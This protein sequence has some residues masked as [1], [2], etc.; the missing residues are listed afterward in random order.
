MKKIFITCAVALSALLSS[1]DMGIMPV[2]P[3]NEEEAVETV[4]DCRRFRAGFYTAFR[5]QSGSVTQLVIPEI[6]ADCF[7]ALAPL[8]GNNA[9]EM[10]KANFLP[11]TDVFGSAWASLYSGIAGVNFYLPRVEKLLADGN[12]SEANRKEIELGRGEAHFFR[13]F[14]YYRLFDLFC[15][16][17]SDELKD[18]PAL[19]LPLVTEYY[20]TTDRSTYKGRSTMAETFKLIYDDLAI[21]EKAVT[22][23]ETV[24]TENLKPGAAYLNSMVIKALRARLALIQGNKADAVKY[25]NEVINSGIYELAGL[26]TY[27]AVWMADAPEKEVIMM[28]FLNVAEAGSIGAY[29]AAYWTKTD[30]VS[31]WYVPSNSTIDMYDKKDVRRNVFLAQYPLS[32]AGSD[33]NTYCF[34]KYPGNPAY[35]GDKSTIGVNAPKPFRISE[36]YLIVAECGDETAANAALNAVRKARIRMWKDKTYTG[37]ALV[38]Q[39]RL[40]R[41]KELIGEGF[42][43]SDLRRWKEGFTRDNSTPTPNFPYAAFG[44]D[45]F[46]AGGQDLS[47]QA[48]DYRLTWPIPLSEIQ[49]N[50]Q[51]QGQQNPGYPAK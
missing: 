44:Q 10:F 5:G 40:E 41:K 2:G 33:Y 1:C 22:D 18:K 24:S 21:A 48:G 12:L 35:E 20:P 13:A 46:V 51:I 7:Q 26:D 49:V 36:M 37:Q 27:A 50:P 14:Y 15:Q 9:G 19:G 45:F 8:Y 4:N 23:Y 39:V 31:A 6:Q 47:Y 25:A 16:T 29:G 32:I 30:H 3:I 17:Y 28:P 11:A 42:R 34:N 43:M 38:D